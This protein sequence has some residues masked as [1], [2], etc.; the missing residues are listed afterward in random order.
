[1]TDHRLYAPAAS[2]N[3]DPILEVLR[4]VLPAKGTVLEVA[5]GSGERI[6]HFARHLPQLTFQPTDRDSEALLS[7]SAWAEAAGVENVRPPLILD[8]SASSWPVSVADAIICINMVHISPWSATTGLISG[9][10]AIL[11]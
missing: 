4:T 9:A 10:A 5:S 8:A 11:P 6:V 1:M 3:R 7:I 2:R